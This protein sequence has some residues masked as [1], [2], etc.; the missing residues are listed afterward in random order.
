MSCTVD[1]ASEMQNFSAPN[2]HFE[3]NRFA[4]FQHLLH[5]HDGDRLDGTLPFKGG[6]STVF[7]PRGHVPMQHRLLHEAD[8]QRTFA[9]VLETGDGVMGCLQD[10]ARSE[11]VSAAQISAIGA[12]SGAV[13]GYFDWERKDYLH[14]PV[15]EQVEVAALLGDVALSPSGGPAVHVHLVLSKRDGTALAGHLVEAHVRPTLEV[16][17]TESPA[18]LQKVYD[19]ESGLALIRPRS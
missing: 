15:K 6:Y 18:H 16:I 8:G 10:F 19:P 12:L 7:H 14:I 5:V 11:H 3:E 13:L 1:F 2:R 17:L 9:L 4:S